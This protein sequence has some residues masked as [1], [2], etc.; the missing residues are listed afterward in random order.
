MFRLHQSDEERE[1]KEN[2]E[3]KENG[4]RIVKKMAGILRW[5]EVTTA[6]HYKKIK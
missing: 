1:H 3:K 6:G 2:C 5:Q 4:K